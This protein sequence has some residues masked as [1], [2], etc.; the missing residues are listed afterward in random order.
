MVA[1]CLFEHARLSD[2][3]YTLSDYGQPNTAGHC[4][5][6]GHDPR[7]PAVPLQA[8]DEDPVDLHRIDRKPFQVDQRCVARPKV[9]A[10]AS[11]IMRSAVS[12]RTRSGS[13]L[14][15]RAPATKD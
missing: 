6:S 2:G 9:I 12:L 13:G 10:V 7:V 4:D 11:E 14:R 3:L 5:H 15:L 1:T 8:T